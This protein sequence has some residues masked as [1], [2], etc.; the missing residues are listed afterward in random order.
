MM[1]S[2]SFGWFL[3]FFAIAN[4]KYIS[5]EALDEVEMPDFIENQKS[6]ISL[7]WIQNDVMEII[8]DDKDRT[9]DQIYLKPSQVIPGSQDPCVMLGT[10]AKD[11]EAMAAVVGCRNDPESIINIATSEH[12]VRE[13]V[14]KNGVTLEDIA[15]SRPKRSL[16]YDLDYDYDDLFKSK[17]P[18]KNKL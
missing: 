11:S 1:R 4:S 6:D 14:L 9:K 2:A 12:K 8:W 15:V 5:Q 18:V 3:L 10:F 17:F 7:Q 16:D 13:L